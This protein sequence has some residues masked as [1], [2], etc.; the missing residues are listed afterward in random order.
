MLRRPNISSNPATRIVQAA[1]ELAAQLRLHRRHLSAHSPLHPRQPRR[2][3]RDDREFWQFRPYQPGDPLRAIDW[4]KTA[5]ADAVMIRERER[6]DDVTISIWLDPSPNMHFSGSP[7]VPEKFERGLTMLLA[8]IRTFD[9]HDMQARAIID[10]SAHRLSL[11]ELV[12]LYL[13]GDTP[14]IGDL[15][16]LPFPRG[17]VIL[18]SDFWQDVGDT[19][20]TIRL[21]RARKHDVSLL[22]IADPAELALP[23]NG[24]VR[25]NA[26]DGQD[27][28]LIESVTDIRT[29]YQER[30]ATHINRLRMGTQAEAARLIT[31]ATDQ[32]PINALDTLTNGSLH[33]RD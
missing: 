18:I 16:A 27:D 6:H 2:T 22:Q 7:A 19:M 21:L 24:R 30:I 29:L 12:Q 10:T 28:E 17:P 1:E 20:T 9:H 23:Y 13:H 25:F 4:R 15:A 33:V 8:L 14:R 5:H 3:A 11:M 32:P 31:H 26:T